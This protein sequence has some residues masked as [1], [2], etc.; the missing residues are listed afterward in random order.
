MLEV[1]ALLVFM[2][3]VV[4]GAILGAIGVCVLALVWKGGKDGRKE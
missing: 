1:S 2:I 3:G 4:V